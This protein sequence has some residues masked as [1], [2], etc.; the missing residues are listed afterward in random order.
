M[1]RDLPTTYLI[2]SFN[3]AHVELAARIKKRDLPTT[4]L[5]KS[6]NQAHVELAARI[7][8]RDPGLAPAVGDRVPYVMVK[9]ESRSESAAESESASASESAS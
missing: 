5:I 7:K 9:G 6:F 8:K 1:K 2:N 4:Y 3:Q